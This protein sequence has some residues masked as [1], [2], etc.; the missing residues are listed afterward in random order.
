MP[1]RKGL[2]KL[3]DAKAM[4]MRA[5]RDRVAIESPEGNLWIGVIEQ[6]MFDAHLHS[7]GGKYPSVAYVAEA[8]GYFRTH[9]FENVCA[10]LGL[11]PEWVRGMADALGKLAKEMRGAEYLQAVIPTA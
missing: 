1:I 2:F 4:I 6:A 11:E 10:M 7:T 9:E 3:Y 5:I 8:R